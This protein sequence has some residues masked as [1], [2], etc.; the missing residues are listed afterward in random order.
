MDSVE[1][2]TSSL[3]NV[4]GCRIVMAQIRFDLDPAK[5]ANPDLDIR[6]L[7]PDRLAAIPK[8]TMTDSGYDYSE[9]EPPVLMVFVNSEDPD[10]DVELAVRFLATNTLLENN[11]LDAATILSSDKA[12]EWKQRY[13]SR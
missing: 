11:I 4:V 10:A 7:L 12:E 2:N 1:R 5:V 9:D 8:S 3:D 6:Y 13:P